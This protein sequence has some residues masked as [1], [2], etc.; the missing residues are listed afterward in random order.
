MGRQQRSFP[1]D[2]VLHVVNRGNDRRRLFDDDVAFREFFR[3]MERVREDIPLRLLAYVLMPNHWHLVVWPRTPGELARFLHR[4][5]GMHAA[6]IRRSTHTVGHGHIYQGRYHA[7]VID[8]PT[9]Y[10]NVV[11][12]V[13]ANPV[14]AGLVQR[15]EHWRW[16]S[17]RDRLHDRP[18]TCDGPF[19]QPDLEDWIV[20][21]NASCPSG[22]PLLTDP[23]RRAR[24]TPLVPDPTARGSGGV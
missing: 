10:L 19:G 12:Y 21:V 17:L 24:T 18:S 4:V 15:A 9:K 14:R 23:A 20:E 8:S 6:R 13:E 5:T 11:R 22:Q 1:G 7:F 3:L 16:S 2:S